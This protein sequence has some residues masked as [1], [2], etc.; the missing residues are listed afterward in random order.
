M[1]EIRSAT[2]FS[3]WL[4]GGRT[5]G[6]VSEMQKRIAPIPEQRACK[7]EIIV[8]DVSAEVCDVTAAIARMGPFADQTPAPAGADERNGN[9]RSWLEVHGR[10][11][12]LAGTLQVAGISKRIARFKVH[13]WL[14]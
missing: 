14:H 2:S 5:C 8:C 9:L 11:E 6:C 1:R 12:G 13:V 4:Q 10:I 7:S 3:R